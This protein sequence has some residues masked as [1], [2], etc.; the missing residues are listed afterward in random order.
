MKSALRLLA[1]GFILLLPQTALA[2]LS[3][4]PISDVTVVAEKSFTVNIVAVDPDGGAIS[5]SATLPAFGTLNDPKTGTGMVVTTATLSPLTDDTGTYPA[6]VTATVGETSDTEAFQ[7]TVTAADA[8]GPPR[9]TAPPSVTGTEASLL[10]FN[11]TASDPEGDPITSLTATGLPTGATFTP[12]GDFLSGAFSWTPGLKQA[13]HYDVVFAA[14]NAQTDSA[15]THIDVMPSNLGPVALAPIADVTMAEGDTAKVAVIATDPDEETIEVSATLPSFATLDA[16][17][18]SADV[19]SLQTTITIMPG[20][21]TAGT[22]PATVKAKSGGDSTTVTF[23]I[24]VTSP[25]LSAT[26]SLIGSYNVHKKFL[27]FKVTPVDSSFDLLDVSLSSLT[28]SFHGQSITAVRPTHL[29]YDCESRC[30]S[31]G[32]SD[33][34]RYENDG[35]GDGNDQGEDDDDDDADADSCVASHIMACFGMNAIKTLFAGFP[36]PDSL[37]AATIEGDLKD[38]SSFVATIGGKHVT[39]QHNHGDNGDG[40]EDNP[41]QGKGKGKLALRVHPNP[42]NPKADI[43]FTLAQ[44]SHVRVAIFDLSGR[45]VKTIHDGD[46]PAGANTVSWD[47]SAGSGVRA[48]SGLY[49][50]K[51]ET[52]TTHEVQRLTVLK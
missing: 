2:T 14:S 51:V 39:D 24:T 18:S 20:T 35:G 43:S 1:M 45:L 30:D 46:L 49:F 7:V 27:C 23:N 25:A 52:A 37:A 48:A 28:L 9:V 38:G 40:N 17:T 4:S 42:M 6:S 36:L 21:G 15:T 11:V 8:N 10:Q 50:V 47:G 34:D 22:Y 44:A 12:A 16:P 33:G 29:A 19:E 13:G 26:A 3:V 32:E 31:C 5:V 41:G